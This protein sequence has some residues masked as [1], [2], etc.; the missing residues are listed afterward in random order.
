MKQIILLISLILFISCI[1]AI[2]IKGG[3][4]ITFDVGETFQYYDIVGNST[5]LSGISI[6]S[7]GTNITISAD[8]LAEEDEFTIIFFNEK[9]VVKEVHI[10]GGSSGSRVIYRN[11]TIEKEVPVYIN[12]TCEDCPENPIQETPPTWAEIVLYLL[13]GVGVVIFLI[14]LRNILKRRLIE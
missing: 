10:G 7:E 1:S 14:G 11:K 5:D 4:S 2:S 3:E 8:Y 12:N 9:E 6:T 13:M